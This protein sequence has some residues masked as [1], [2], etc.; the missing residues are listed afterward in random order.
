MRVWLCDARCGRVA[1]RRPPCLVARILSG[2]R[3]KLHLHQLQPIVQPVER[4]LIDVE[5]D[6]LVRVRA[7]HG[8]TVLAGLARRGGSGD[9]RGLDTSLHAHGAAAAR[10]GGAMIGDSLVV[11]ATHRVLF[12]HESSDLVRR[13][14]RRRSLLHLFLVLG[15][16]RCVTCVLLLVVDA[17]KHRAVCACDV[18][19]AVMPL[20][21]RRLPHSSLFPLPSM[22]RG[23]PGGKV[24]LTWRHHEQSRN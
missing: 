4:G 24:W 10:D 18:C 13:A 2:H 12:R 14:G 20:R 7:V 22:A 15:G 17:R 5:A 19:V 8:A 9:G 11:V 3:R 21:W 6:V 23:R 1:W 16:G